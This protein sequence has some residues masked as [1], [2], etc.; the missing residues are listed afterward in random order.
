MLSRRWRD[1]NMPLGSSGRVLNGPA[2]LA[3]AG[4]LADM[5][6]LSCADEANDDAPFGNAI[7]KLN[8][9]LGFRLVVRSIGVVLVRDCDHHEAELEVFDR[10]TGART[11][12]SPA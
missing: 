9:Q 7:G 2:P 10:G 8:E 11:S 4:L 5:D 12:S 3:D 1:V 6:F